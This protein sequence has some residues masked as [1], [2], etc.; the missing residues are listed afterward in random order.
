MFFKEDSRGNVH[1]TNAL[2][3]SVIGLIW[4]ALCV[5]GFFH[6]TWNSWLTWALVILLAFILIVGGAVAIDRMFQRWR[7]K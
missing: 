1:A 5:V 7:D 3:D 6:M 2:F 4:L